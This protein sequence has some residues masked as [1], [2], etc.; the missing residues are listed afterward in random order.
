L[1]KN[2]QVKGDYYLFIVNLSLSFYVLQQKKVT[3]QW[4]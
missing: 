3:I 4:I 2:K 1:H